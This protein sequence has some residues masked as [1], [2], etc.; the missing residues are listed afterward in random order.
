MKKSVVIVVFFIVSNSVFG[1]EIFTFNDCLNLT[2]KNNLLL[3]SAVNDEQ[4][5]LYQYKASYGKLLPSVYILA[6]NKNS[7]GREIDQNTNLFVDKE[8]KYYGG[9]INAVFNLFSGF[10]TINT[11]K[12]NRLD[13]KIN[14]ANIEKV[15]NE[16]TISLAQKFITILYL[17]EIIIANQEQIKSSEKQLELAILKYTSG[18]ISESEVFKIRSQKAT[19]ELNLLTNENHLTDNFISLKQLM[20][21]P[22]EKEIKLVKPALELHEN[23]L[24]EDN[25]FSLTK[26]AI[27]INPLHSMSLLKEKKA[28]T[29]L[30]L[31]RGS[32]YPV[33]SMRLL[34]GSNYTDNYFD[35]NEVLIPNNDQIQNNFIKGLRLNLSIPIFSQLEN[36][37]KIKTSRLNYKQSKI[38]TQIIQNNLSKEVLKAITDTKTSI[39]K[40]ESSA[41][42]F[43]FSQKSYDAD[44]LKF[45]L[46]KINI[47]ELNNT[48]MIY[49][50]SQVELIQS[51]YE[52]LFNNALI[53]F[54]LGDNFSL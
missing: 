50:N 25:P 6:E 2:I 28:R 36:F 47:N 30:S 26:Q 13:V 23:I 11:I 39:K 35:K 18:A 41:M 49:N 32:R 1:Q 16:I 33:L 24:L 48:K 10:T 40:N 17:E 38:D 34:S 5:A 53:K 54:Y 52:L 20:N 4:I 7:W 8:L 3:K 21:I 44:I 43:E 22:L 42:A 19:E 46:G 29:S 45:E 31:A 27:E 37:S 14:R 51:K 15:K 12:S 9:N